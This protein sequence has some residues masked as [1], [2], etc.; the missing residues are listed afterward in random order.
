MNTYLKVFIL[1]HLKILKVERQFPEVGS[2]ER[3]SFLLGYKERLL[4]HWKYPGQ[5]IFC[6]CSIRRICR[7]ER[8]SWAVLFGPDLKHT[9]LEGISGVG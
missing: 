9:I 3:I 4:I 1:K 2:V 6:H 8:G 7:I 5:M